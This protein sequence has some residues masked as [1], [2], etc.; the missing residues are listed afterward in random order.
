MSK[1]D[2]K[3]TAKKTAKKAGILAIDGAKKVGET[4][5]NNPKTTLYIVGGVVVSYALYKLYKGISNAFN[6][7]VDDE[8]TGT[9][10]GNTSNATIT[11]N[12]AANYAQQLLDAMNEQR[13][14]WIGGG[15]DE[16][17]IEAVFD[18]LKNGSDF[19]LVYQAFGR[20]DYNGF[21]SP[22]EGLEM[23]DTYTPRDLVYWLNSEIGSFW[24]SSL[25]T[26]VKE[27]V[28]SAGFS[29]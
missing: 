2:Y 22:I 9:G 24:D 4:V 18:K 3:K 23:F 25:H 26:K 12:Q 14:S 21:N 5:S 11:Q 27:R 15:T 20:K 13:N 6:P 28:E 29:F 10:G 1:T 16:D 17:T 19:L 7:V 8:V